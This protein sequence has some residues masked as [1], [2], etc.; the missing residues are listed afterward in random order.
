MGEGAR[1]CGP[2]A[3]CTDDLTESPNNAV[4]SGPARWSD[5][6]AC[7]VPWLSMVISARRHAL[8]TGLGWLSGCISSCLPTD[9]LLAFRAVQHDQRDFRAD[10]GTV[11]DNPV[12]AG[13]L[14]P[15]GLQVTLAWGLPDS[16]SASRECGA[17]P[18]ACYASVFLVDGTKHLAEVTGQ[19][20]YF[21]FWLLED[22][23]LKGLSTSPKQ[24]PPLVSERGTV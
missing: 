9:Q 15:G 7:S 8:G 16:A 3:H 22:L 17:W 1:R 24:R 11:H 19:G 23:H 20:I 4:C 13:I 6:P 5:Y 21:A 18:A 2:W 12:V 10:V 14:Q